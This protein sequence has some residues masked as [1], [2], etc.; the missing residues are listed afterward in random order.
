MSWGSLKWWVCC[1]GVLTLAACGSAP[2][3]MPSGP[4]ATAHGTYKVGSPYQVNGVWYYPKED[5][6]YDKTGIASW[7]GEKFN[8]R[9]T[10]DGEIFNLN[11]L[12]AAH[13][14]L[15][16]PCVVRV[17]NLEN[18]RSIKLRVNDRGPFVGSRIIDV[19]RRAAQLLG[20]ERQGTTRVRVQLMRK[21]SLRVAAL[22]GRPGGED[23][24]GSPTAPPIAVASAGPAP[25]PPAQPSKPAPALADASTRPVTA[26]PR[27]RRQLIADNTRAVLARPAADP[28]PQPVPARVDPPP[29]LAPA[30]PVTLNAPQLFIQ[31]GAFSD[32]KNALRLRER[33]RGLGTPVQVSGSAVNGVAVYRVRLG[34]AA[35]VDA[36][37]ALLNRVMSDGVIEARIVSD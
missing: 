10:A 7:Y 18:G 11:D 31:A 8:H 15:Q 26:R 19:S 27:P 23:I 4:V 5:W 37:N 2:H 20:F 14:T 36:A 24:A 33:L 6:S 25:T 22:A 12:T 29:P 28:A 30:H 13:K 1:A 35:S 34:P 16:L 9:R 21:D 32:E 17:T 3:H